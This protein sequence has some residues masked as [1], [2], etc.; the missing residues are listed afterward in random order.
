MSDNIELWK[1]EHYEEHNIKCFSQEEVQLKINELLEEYPSLMWGT[2]LNGVVRKLE[3]E[4]NISIGF[5]QHT[6]FVKNVRE[7]EV[8]YVKVLRFKTKELCRL[9]CTAPTLIDLN[10]TFE[11][12]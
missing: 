4:E 3:T 6:A 10:G 12:S 8:Y 1:D 2:H 9:H 5:G 11:V 7:F